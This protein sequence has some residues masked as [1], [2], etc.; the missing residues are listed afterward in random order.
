MA[1]EGDEA[2]GDEPADWSALIPRFVHPTQVIVIETM[3][4]IG[5][6]LSATELEKVAGGIPVLGTFSYHLKRLA[7]LGALEVVGKS[8]V[9]KSQ[10]ANEETFFYFVAQRQWITEIVLSGDPADPLNEVALSLIVT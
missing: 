3:L 6:P 10:G 7:E 5:R 1:G 4:W 8:K 2:S 9:R